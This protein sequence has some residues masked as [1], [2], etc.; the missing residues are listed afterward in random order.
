MRDGQNLD[1]DFFCLPPQLE[2]IPSQIRKKRKKADT[3]ADT[4]TVIYYFYLVAYLSSY[5]E[6]ASKALNELA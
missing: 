1:L 4:Y 3:G 5:H 2:A 6:K